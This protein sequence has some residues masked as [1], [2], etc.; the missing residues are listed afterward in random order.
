MTYLRNI[1]L[2]LIAAA[3]AAPTLAQE[4]SS[5]IE[6]IVVTAQKRESSLQDT[7]VAI[8]AFD[9]SALDR[10]N[11]DDAMDVQFAVP[12][13][14]FTK[15][16]FSASSLAIRGI[17]RSVVATSGD[18]GVGIHFNGAYL[19]QSSI[20][21]SEFFD[22]ERVEILRGPQGTLYGRNTTGG[23]VNIIPAKADEEFGFS[24]DGQLGNYDTRKGHG[25]VNIPINDMLQFRLSGMILDR[26]GYTDNDFTGNEIDDRD[27]WSTRVAMRFVPTDNLEMNFFWQHFDEDDSR[28]RT[29]K[30]FCS[31]DTAGLGLPGT[32]GFPFNLGCNPDADIDT[33]GTANSNASLGGILPTLP[34]LPGGTSL[35]PLGTDAFANSVVDGDPR[36]VYSDFDP[37]YSFEEDI[38]NIEIVYDLESYTLTFNGSYQESD[39]FAQTDYDWG[40]ASETFTPNLLGGLL[41]DA[42]GNLATPA[43]PTVSGYNRLFAY[44][45]SAYKGDTYTAEARIQSDW[46]ES[47]FDFLFGGFYLDHQT[48]KGYY[49]VHANTLAVLAPAEFD[50]SGA[51]LSYFRSNTEPYELET[52]A[53]FGEVYWDV[54]D[55]VRLTGGL[56]YSD[57]QKEVKDRQSL[58]NNPTLPYVEGITG[59]SYLNGAVAPFMEAIGITDPLFQGF[60]SSGGGQNPNNAVPDFRQFKDDWQETTGKFGVEWDADIA[61]FDESLLFATYA[62]SYKSGGINPPSFTGAFQPTFDPEYI[63]SFEIGAK[64]R[65]FD[66]TVQANVN[67]FFYDYDDL[68]TTKIID[69]TS[70]NENIDAEVMG[71]EAE[72][73]WVPTDALRI[74][75]FVSWLDTDIDS[76]SSTNPNNPTAGNPDWIVVKNS[77]AD[78]FLAPNPFTGATFDPA[79]CGVTVECATIFESSPVDA[80]GNALAVLPDT[81][82]VPTGVPVDVSGNKLPNAPEWSF[83]IGAE[84][85]FRLPR[86]LELVPRIDYYWQD[87]MY[88][89]IYNTNQDEIES[90]DVWNASVT[91]FSGDGAWYAEGFVKNIA[92]DENITGGYFTD[93]SS[94]NFNNVFILEPRTYGLT[95]GYRM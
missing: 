3:V 87:D 2:W 41:T 22:V 19:Q 64:T 39:Y 68:Q 8:S 57:E 12:N 78:I 61:F 91:L 66:N 53:L 74:D 23:V 51:P 25:M 83:S 42:E 36:T 72:F 26:D 33:P 50:A 80:A 30:Q 16:N 1:S 24:V 27:L 18:S 59:R 63:D 35:Y 69:R 7:A 90:W 86:N 38:Y 93:Y 76:G 95:V 77:G 44:D 28:M 82:L 60:G 71:M 5:P 13:M 73:V 20:F 52:W 10:Q 81:T 92:D 29:N 34:I 11:I 67:W 84:Y 32:A 31:K 6:E 65:M 14:T 37:S 15:T 46:T 47:P 54:T 58:L 40:V 9:Q 21:E 4:S 89:R 79:D 62:R 70:V 49:D 43:D 94:G 85:S 56:R 55:R 45:T 17:G 48:D 75:A 88:Y